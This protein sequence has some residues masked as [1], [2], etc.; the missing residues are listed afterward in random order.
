MKKG[1]VV[2]LE[3][4][5]APEY[6][7]I[8]RSAVEGIAKRMC[9]DAD[10]IED[11]KIAVGEACTNAIKY[12]CPRDDVHNVDIRCVV[13]EDGL[14][15]EVRNNVV[16]CCRLEVPDHPDLARE[17]GLGLYLIRHL[18]DQVDFEWN[19]DTATVKMLKRLQ[20]SQQQ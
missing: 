18:V 10:Q 20:P 16:G 8:V 5:S 15:V 11:L 13:C 19:H 3:I 4:P 14:L 12:G 2:E 6:V 9:F 7:S 1:E 17:G